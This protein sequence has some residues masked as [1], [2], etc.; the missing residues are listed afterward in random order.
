M[1]KPNQF[2][3]KIGI[4]VS[5]LRRWDNENILKARRT[6]T[7]HRYYTDEDIQG[8]KISKVTKRPKMVIIK[9]LH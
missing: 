5:T 2:A 6:Q 3:K 8:Y 1:G 7:N 9:S 4:S